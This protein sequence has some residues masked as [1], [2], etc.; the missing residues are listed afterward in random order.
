MSKE[1]KK[2]QIVGLDIG[3]SKIVAIVAE[4]DDEG[5]LSVLGVGS[6]ESKGLKRG[7]VVNIEATVNA[8]SRAIQEVELMTNA[9][10]TD[11]YTGIAGGHIK[12]KDSNG[13]AV[14]SD[15]EVTQLDVQ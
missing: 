12:S 10:V 1:S 13:M 8:I 6:Q 4:M 9:K 15:K 11:V 14:V 5:R 7:V 2:D 3:T